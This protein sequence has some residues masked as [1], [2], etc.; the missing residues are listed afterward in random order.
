MPAAVDKPKAQLASKPNPRQIAK[1]KTSKELDAILERVEDVGEWPIAKCDETNVPLN[2]V[3]S[4]PDEFNAR[5]TLLADNFKPRN[6]QIDIEVYE[7]EAD[8]KEDLLAL[9]QLVIVPLYEAA[10]HQLKT[11]GTCFFWSKS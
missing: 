10:T 1:P 9:V 5:W 2:V 7:V 3:I 8:C 11:K 6:A 4:E